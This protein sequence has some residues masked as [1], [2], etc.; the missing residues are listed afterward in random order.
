MAFIQGEHSNHFT[1][2]K[3][4]MPIT[5]PGDNTSTSLYMTEASRHLSSK[6][7][8]SDGKKSHDFVK[9]HLHTI[10]IC[11]PYVYTCTYTLYY[12][13]LGLWSTNSAGLGPLKLN[14]KLWCSVKKT[15]ARKQ[16]VPDFR[17]PELRC[18]LLT[19][20]SCHSA[21]LSAG[22]IEKLRYN[23]TS[24][25]WLWITISILDMPSPFVA[26]VATAC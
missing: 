6:S 15:K 25:A 13:L 11:M 3:G 26:V 10:C 5:E 7:V 20:I 14:V 2:K 4:F 24:V 12:L 18:F 19:A 1:K 23:Q 9:L 22:W 16:S 17:A 21:L 8:W